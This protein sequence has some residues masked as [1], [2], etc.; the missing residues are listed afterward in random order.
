MSLHLANKL[1]IT[2][3]NLEHGR[4]KTSMVAQKGVSRRFIRRGLM[5]QGHTREEAN[6]IMK[7]M[8]FPPIKQ[9]V[10]GGK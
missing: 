9:R 5:K 2:E 6:A 4:L 8:G 3:S 1:S 7:N 10:R